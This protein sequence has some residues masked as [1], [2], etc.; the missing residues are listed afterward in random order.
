MCASDN[1]FGK[2]C[3]FLDATVQ[4][5]ILDA[6]RDDV[7]HFAIVALDCRTWSGLANPPFRSK[8]LLFGL[9]AVKGKRLQ[10]C[11]EHNKLNY[12]FLNVVR[13]CNH[14]KV[15]VLLEN[16]ASTMLRDVDEMQYWHNLLKDSTVVTDYC[17]FGM[18]YQKRTRVLCSVPGMA[19][20][21]RKCECKH[22]HRVASKG[23]VKIAGEW[24]ARCKVPQA[25]TPQLC[26]EIAKHYTATVS[27]SH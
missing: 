14:H 13:T 11:N 7:F 9:P 8:A 10:I 21:V 16:G 18:P 6:I 5:R 27:V 19:G 1:S 24:R 23:R 2:H 3:N 15:A 22:K 4:I 25:Y 12:L 26:A 20:I 17:Q